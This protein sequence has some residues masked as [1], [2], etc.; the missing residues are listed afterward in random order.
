MVRPV[1]LRDLLTLHHHL[2]M[3][4]LVTEQSVRCDE[5]KMYLLIGLHDVAE[6]S[7][8]HLPSVDPEAGSVEGDL[9]LLHVLDP[10]LAL[11][12]LV[13]R[14]VE[15][16]LVEQDGAAGAAHVVAAALWLE[17]STK[18]R[19]MFTIFRDIP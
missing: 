2:E 12:H 18:F 8:G 17:P 16:A 9:H 5:F 11:L 6:V 13:Q 14:Q 19:E 7:L 15:G 1:L 3:G 4:Q 10:E